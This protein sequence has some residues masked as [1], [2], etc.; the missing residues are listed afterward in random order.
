MA[1]FMAFA[2]IPASI[3]VSQSMVSS[4]RKRLAAK[5]STNDSTDL[6]NL[7]QVKLIVSGA[8][9]ESVGNLAAIAFL[10]ERQAG[11]LGLALACVIAVAILFPRQEQVEEWLDD[12]RQRLEQEREFS[13]LPNE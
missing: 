7:Y 2:M 9:S 3:I 8:L 4:G 12:Q 10:I 6:L 1:Y 13:E 5:P 11:T